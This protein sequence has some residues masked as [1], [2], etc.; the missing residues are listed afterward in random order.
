MSARIEA[1]LVIRGAR[2]VLTLDGPPPEASRPHD[3]APLGVIPRG[4]V[5]VRAE[6]IVALGPEQDVLDRVQLTVDATVVDACGGI[7]TPGLVDAHTH[8]LFVGDRADEYADRLA[9]ASYADIASRGG[10]I[11]RSV[12]DLRAAT[13]EALIDA[14]VARLER[15]RR[16]G[17]TTVEVK[18]GY[19]LDTASELRALRAIARARDRVASTS[20]VFRTFLPL[21]AVDPD[22]RALPDGR[23]RYLARTLGETVPAALAEGPDFVDAYVDT[24]GF[25]VEETRPLLQLAQ[26]AGVGV[27]MHVGQFAD[28]GGAELAAEFHAASADHLEHVGDSGLRAM[29]SANVVA[30]LLPGAAFSLGQT[31]PDARRFRAAGLEVAIATDCNPGT[32]YTENLPLMA[33]FAV[34]QMGL[35][36]PEAWWAITRAA[37]R[38]LRSETL[39][40]LRVGGPADLVVMDLPGWQALPYRFGGAEARFTSVGNVG[41]GIKK[42]A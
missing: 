42:P 10:G 21:H 12:R 19:G 27:R 40:A 7:V 34:R 28:V 15:M 41:D 39:G 16:Y 32:S 18:T 2:E 33:A 13:D 26:A 37:A 23:A 17:T 24:T 11:A 30:V 9:G 3:P 36:I 29:A 6:R 4:A 5:A 8:A 14:L 35:S 20:R 38:S 31:P 1:D 25:S 22:L